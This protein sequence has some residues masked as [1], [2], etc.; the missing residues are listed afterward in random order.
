MVRASHGP[1]HGCREKG[2][3]H[4]ML[5]RGEKTHTHKHTQ[6]IALAIESTEVHLHPS[7]KQVV[8]W[9]P[10]EAQKGSCGQSVG[11][12][13]MPRPPWPTSKGTVSFSLPRP[14]PSPPFSSVFPSQI[15]YSEH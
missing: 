14:A 9:K 5:V 15:P 10:P 2:Q 1:E 12:P 13:S 7:D 6:T 3:K 11:G 4:G 8:F